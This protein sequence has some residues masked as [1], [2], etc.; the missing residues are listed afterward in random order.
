MVRAI[1][2]VSEVV[3]NDEGKGTKNI[4]SSPY[5]IKI[6]KRGIKILR[7]PR[8]VP[9]GDSREDDKNKGKTNNTI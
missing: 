2:K 3:Y 4:I 9:K 7:G 8:R 6:D 1:V 5:V